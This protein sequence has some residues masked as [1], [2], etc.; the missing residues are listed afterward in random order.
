MHSIRKYLSG[1]LI[2]AVLSAFLLLANI[3]LNKG[4]PIEN[5][6]WVSECLIIKDNAVI[7]LDPALVIVSGS[8][9]L[10]GFSA[11]KL[12]NTYGIISVNAAIHAGLGIDYTLHYA[13]RYLKPGRIIVL[14]LEYEQYTKPSKD[15]TFIHQALNYDSSYL[16]KLSVIEKIEF[17]GSIPVQVHMSLIKNFIFPSKQSSK[18]Y[19]SK[20]LNK[21]GDETKNDWSND[22]KRKVVKLVNRLKRSGDIYKHN[23]RA[24][25]AIKKFIKDARESNTTVVLAHPN[26]FNQSINLTANEEFFRELILRAE[27]IGINII[28][29]AED[30]LY[31]SSRIY[32]TIYH[33]NSYGQ[34]ISTDILYQQLHRNGVIE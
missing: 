22:E 16:D 6:R 23:D 13:R 33:Q 31:N 25:D 3:G 4:R 1:I 19:D 20:T 8:N 11:E 10:F 27:K 2:G 7:K 5:G 32:D 21:F 17:I 34:S 30:R 26:R 18:G 28:G 29:S 14:P 24:W 9:S 15:P 12:T